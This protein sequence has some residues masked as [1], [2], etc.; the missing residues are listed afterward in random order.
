MPL[1]RA[2]DLGSGSPLARLR[3]A[4]DPPRLDAPLLRDVQTALAERGFDPGPVDGA[5]GPAT[6]AA[7]AL[8]REA[9]GLPPG[10]IVDTGL[11][12]RL[13]LLAR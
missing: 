2:H 10:E 13:D 1:Q 6:R 7:V 11:L 8:F 12:R 3:R 9:E 4:P 5:L